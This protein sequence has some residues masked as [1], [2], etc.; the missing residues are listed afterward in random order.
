MARGKLGGGLS[1]EFHALWRQRALLVDF[2]IE[3]GDVLPGNELLQQRG[4]L[5]GVP[6]GRAYVGILARVN[7]VLLRDESGAGLQTL[8]RAGLDT[9]ITTSR[10]IQ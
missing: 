8:V 10:R 5:W 6:L 3:D 2:K 4:K 1:E 9:A 7:P